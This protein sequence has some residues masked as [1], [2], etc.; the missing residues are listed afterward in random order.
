MVAVA[1]NLTGGG[2]DGERRRGGGATALGGGGRRAPAGAPA[3]WGL[4]VGIWP[5]LRGAS[6]IFARVL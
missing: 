6:S 1:A 3:Q 4:P 5:A 2:A